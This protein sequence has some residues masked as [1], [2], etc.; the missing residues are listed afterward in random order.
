MDELFFLPSATVAMPRAYWG[1]DVKLSS[2]LLLIEP[3]AEEFGRIIKA[4]KNV[5]QGRYD[6]EIVND[7]YADTAMIIPHRGYDLL[8]GEFRASDHKAYL[9]NANEVWEPHRILAEAKFLHFSDWP[10]SKPWIKSREYKIEENQPACV[11]TDGVLDCENRN[12]WLGFYKDFADRRSLV[13]G[14]ELKQDSGMRRKRGAD[15]GL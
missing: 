9:G 14:L 11:E 7:L 8:T 13:C 12:I 3:S 10:V 4:F 2:Q 5:T 1:V 15:G 6:M